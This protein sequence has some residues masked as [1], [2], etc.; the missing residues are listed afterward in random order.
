MTTTKANKINPSTNSLAVT[1]LLFIASGA[2]SLVFV[3]ENHSLPL[4]AFGL[5]CALNIIAPAV[6]WIEKTTTRENLLDIASLLH[7]VR[8]VG[9]YILAFELMLNGGASFFVEPKESYTLIGL[10]I[11]LGALPLFW[12]LMRIQK[13]TGFAQLAETSKTGL[14]FA[15]LL[16]V[17]SLLSWA[18]NT[19]YPEA[20]AGLGLAY[21]AFKEGQKGTAQGKCFCEVPR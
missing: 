1:M 12:F 21:V 7:R 20:I 19:P 4:L 5:Y 17:S 9:F 6:Y 16:S 15:G 14:F 3:Q 11:G 10:W 18:T 2:I 8:G 13:L